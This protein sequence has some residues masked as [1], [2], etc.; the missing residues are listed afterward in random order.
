MILLLTGPQGA[1]KTTTARIVAAQLDRGVHLEGDVFRRFIV[2][3]RADMTPDPSADAL[4]QLRLRYELA[5]RAAQAYAAAGF[6]VVVEDVVA[7]PMLATMAVRYDRVVVLFPSQE[8]VAQRAGARD[9]PWVY[10]LFAD[11]TPRIGTWID[12]SELTPEQ[13]AAA[14]LRA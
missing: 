2:A 10:R 4:A 9:A 6:D 1:G 8:T 11:E 14:I 7:G 3:G 12:T 13:A 5:T